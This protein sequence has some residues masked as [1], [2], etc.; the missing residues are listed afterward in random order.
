MLPIKRTSRADEDLISIWLEIAKNNPVAADRILDAI[1]SC[2][3]QLASHPF[4]GLAR[5]DIGSGIRHL[6]VGSYLTLYRIADD[7]IDIVRVLH[8]RRKITRKTI[9]DEGSSGR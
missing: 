4:F 7:R 8:G 6:V 2:W 3:L 1:E 9:E 5:N